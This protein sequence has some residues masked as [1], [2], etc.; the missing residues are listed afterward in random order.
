MEQELQRP[1]P[2][3]RF[4]RRAM[5]AA[6]VG[7]FIG[8]FAALGGCHLA[9]STGTS[10]RV[11]GAVVVLC[12]NCYLPGMPQDSHFILLDGYTGDIWAYSDAAVVSGA[13]PMYLGT[14]EAIGKPIIHKRDA[15]GSPTH[16]FKRTPDA[17]SAVGGI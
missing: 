11:G 7:A 14:L 3:D 9:G 13:E 4:Q 2:R 16:S 15:G 1:T 12:S 5:M 8:F 6:L 17:A 10:A